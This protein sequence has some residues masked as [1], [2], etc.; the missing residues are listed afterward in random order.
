M[1]ARLTLSTGSLYGYPLPQILA[2]AGALGLDGVEVMLD[3]IV[4]A[5]GP[6]ALAAAAKR[7][8]TPVLSVHFAFLGCRSAADFHD[9]YEQAAGFAAELPD[10][11]AVVVHTSV[12]ASLHNADGHAYLQALRR[13]QQRLRR[14]GPRLS[15]ENRGVGSVPPRSAYLDDLVNLRRLAEEWDFALTFDIGHAASWGLDITRG[16]ESLGSRVDN[17]HLSNSHARG[18]PFTLPIMHSHLRDHQPLDA[19]V[20]PIDAFLAHLAGRRYAGLVTLELSPLALHLPLPWRARERLADSV[21]RCRAGL[22]VVEAQG[23]GARGEG[24]G[25][26]EVR[27]EG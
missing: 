20:L 18:W 11:E 13:S 8:G 5:S 19:G 6:A 3:D 15:I 10:C 12:A 25:E 16:L 17:I 9:A 14:D 23:R 2:T 21:R 1:T 26:R 27:S 24:R 22:A 4:L 7:A